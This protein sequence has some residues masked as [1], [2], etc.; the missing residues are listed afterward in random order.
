MRIAPRTAR[1]AELLD[2][3]SLSPIADH[4]HQL[5]AT[6]RRRSQ[7]GLA[8]RGI[9]LNGSR[10]RKGVN[11]WCRAR[12]TRDSEHA[13]HPDPETGAPEEVPCTESR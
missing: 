4:E 2:S 8:R 12:R 9:G 1:D 11:M 10:A 3:W 7:P 13:P 6:L 5:G